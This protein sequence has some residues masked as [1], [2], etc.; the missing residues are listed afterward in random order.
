MRSK[1]V[2]GTIRT[3]L[4]IY[5]ALKSF[6]NHTCASTGVLSR[7]IMVAR[8][9]FSNCQPFL[10]ITFSYIPSSIQKLAV[11]KMF[12]FNRVFLIQ[13]LISLALNKQSVESETPAALDSDFLYYELSRLVQP[14]HEHLNAS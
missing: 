8:Y 13:I 14:Y 9:N 7:D 10:D 2:R 1:T 11:T 6:C 12:I 5:F 3:F 4:E